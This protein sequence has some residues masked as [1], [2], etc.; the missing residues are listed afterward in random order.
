M[1]VAATLT[2]CFAGVHEGRDLPTDCPALLLDLDDREA[3]PAGKLGC[4]ATR[5]ASP[6]VAEARAASKDYSMA[7]ATLAPSPG[8]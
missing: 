2:V 5:L 1:T 3:T 7:D 8:A 4:K 6:P